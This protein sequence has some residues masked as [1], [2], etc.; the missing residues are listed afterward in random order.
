MKHRP[1]LAWVARRFALV[2]ML[3]AVVPA[4]AG[5]TRAQAPAEDAQAPT[6]D[7]QAPTEDLRAFVTKWYVHGTPYAEARAYGPGA[8]PDL[9]AMLHD[10]EMEPH[11]VKVVYTLGCIGDP[12]SLFCALVR[13]RLGL[14]PES[15]LRG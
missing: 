6:E 15:L 10:P 4:V 3:T 12:L 14:G 7:A 8:I 1:L 2:P 11:W 13:E 9:V 5:P